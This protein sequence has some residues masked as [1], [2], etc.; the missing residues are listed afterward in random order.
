MSLGCPQCVVA[1][2]S[3]LT[4]TVASFAHRVRWSKDENPFSGMTT[5]LP[6][7]IILET[8]VLQH[9]QLPGTQ[10]LLVEISLAASNPCIK[11]LLCLC[12]FATNTLGMSEE[13]KM[14]MCRRV[15]ASV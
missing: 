1:P 9:T 2:G 13:E 12:G 6:Y 8:T 14:N 5:T 7:Q 4:V 10:S 11:Q 15:A 3:E